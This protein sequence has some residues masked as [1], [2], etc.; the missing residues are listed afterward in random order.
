MS[1]ENMVNTIK[2]IHPN[3]VVIIKIVY[4]NIKV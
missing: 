1:V 2:K 3:Y 4:D